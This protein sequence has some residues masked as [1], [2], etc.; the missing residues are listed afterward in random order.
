MVR[1][2]RDI[3]GAGVELAVSFYFPNFRGVFFS[4]QTLNLIYCGNLAN[5][6]LV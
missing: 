1:P 4:S 2:C 5:E 3:H 6:L